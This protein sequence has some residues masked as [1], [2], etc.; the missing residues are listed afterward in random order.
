M[1]VLLLLLLI[2]VAR[3]VVVV[4][5]IVVVVVVVVGR[6]CRYSLEHF[7]QQFSKCIRRDTNDW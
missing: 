1:S 7:G 3:I 2:V 5:I 4:V 6:H